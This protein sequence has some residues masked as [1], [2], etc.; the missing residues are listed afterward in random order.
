MRRVIFFAFITA[1]FTACTAEFTEEIAPIAPQTLQVS[2]EEDS[3]IHLNEYG[4]TV[5]DANDKV[6]VFYR[7]Y[8]NEYWKYSGET[9][10]T[11]GHL[12]NQGNASTETTKRIVAV[13]CSE[14]RADSA[15]GAVGILAAICG[16][17]YGFAEIPLAVKQGKRYYT[18]GKGCVKSDLFGAYKLVVDFRKLSMRNAEAA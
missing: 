15:C 13:Y 1:L 17:A 6:S 3:R 14:C 2:F 18:N 8:V 5:W 12:V 7:S 4:K 9:G 16:K 11:S 10:S